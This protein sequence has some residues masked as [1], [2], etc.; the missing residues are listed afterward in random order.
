MRHPRLIEFERRL[1]ELFDEVDDVLEEWY[2]SRYDLHPARP[3]RG[4][5]ANKAHDGLFNVGASFTAGFGSRIGRGYVVQVDMATLGRVPP[6]VR[7][8]IEGEVVRL[9]TARLPEYFPDRSLRIDR[10]RHVYKIH[11][12]LRLGEV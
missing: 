1:K 8:T 11:G 2:G 12:D 7:E 6:D 4:S 5:T 3:V 10:D 9:V